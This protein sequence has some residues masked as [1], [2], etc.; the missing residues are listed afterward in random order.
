MTLRGES[1]SEHEIL[2]I[3]VILPNEGQ[4]KECLA[5]IRE[6][7][8]LL[9]RNRYSRDRLLRDVHDGRWIGVRYWASEKARKEAQED[10]EVQRIWERLGRLCTVEKVREQLEEIL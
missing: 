1:P 3:A 6:L 7:Y 10:P 9:E 8:S 2:A 5:T 4:E